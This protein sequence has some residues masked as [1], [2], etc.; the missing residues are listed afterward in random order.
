MKR[1]REREKADRFH[2]RHVWFPVL[3]H[4]FVVEAF[5]VA[6]ARANHC[7]SFLKQASVEWLLGI[8]IEHLNDRFGYLGDESHSS[9]QLLQA[10]AGL[11]RERSERFVERSN[12]E[13]SDLLEAL[14]V[15]LCEP[16][17]H[18]KA[19]TRNY[20][21]RLQQCGTVLLDP[22]PVRGYPLSGCPLLTAALVRDSAQPLGCSGP[23]VKF[24]GHSGRVGE[25]V[26]GRSPAGSTKVQARHGLPGMI[27]PLAPRP[28]LQSA[29]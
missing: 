24:S 19:E 28:I 20:R 16:G 25:E 14:H 12:L 18:D 6:G 3:P 13:S 8:G 23:G 26:G 15:R 27:M 5:T 2:L 1:S 9:A 4:A 29:R 7:A 22:R 10:L 21:Y 17:R 11:E